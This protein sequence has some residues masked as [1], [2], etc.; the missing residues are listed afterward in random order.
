MLDGRVAPAQNEAPS[1]QASIDVDNALRMLRVARI[2]A[3]LAGFVVM[4]LALALCRVRRI[5]S[6]TGW[7]IPKIHPKGCYCKTVAL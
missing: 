7:R 6:G 1:A 3:E 4:L 5:L 2:L